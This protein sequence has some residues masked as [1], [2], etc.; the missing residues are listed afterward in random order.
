MLNG[1]IRPDHGKDHYERQD[2]SVDRTWARA[3][4][5]FLPEGKIF[6]T[7]QPCLGFQKKTLIKDL[8]IL[9]TFAEIGEFLDMP[10]QN[11]SSV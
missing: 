11:Y 7:M 4:A 3:L 2:W 8:R 1:L 10:V 9:S 6:I 5:L